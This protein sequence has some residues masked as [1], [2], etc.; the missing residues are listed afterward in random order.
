MATFLSDARRALPA[1]RQ[2][3]VLRLSSRG[4]FRSRAAAGPSRVGIVCDGKRSSS[5][6]AST[7][8]ERDGA[9]RCLLN[10]CFLQQDADQDAAVSTAAAKCD[11]AAGANHSDFPQICPES[12]GALILLCEL[13]SRLPARARSG[14]T[15]S[16]L[17]GQ[18]HRCS[19]LLSEFERLRCRRRGVVECEVPFGLG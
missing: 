14:L 5:S 12:R 6:V 7:A 2:Q 19:K 4:G 11:R 10:L 3:R 9:G 15:M 1:T 16:M 8:N 13:G 17:N 18:G